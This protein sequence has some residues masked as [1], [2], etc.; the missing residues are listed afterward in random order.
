MK[1]IY[2]FEDP[3]PAVAGHLVD[4]LHRVLHLGVHVEA[5][6][7]RGVSTL[8]KNFPGK[9]VDFLSKKMSE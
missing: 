2:F 3:G 5:S 4:N 1:S 8:A 9:P 6:L 7:H